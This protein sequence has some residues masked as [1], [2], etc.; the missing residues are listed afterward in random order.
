MFSLRLV[1]SALGM[2]HMYLDLL[3]SIDHLLQKQRFPSSPLHGFLLR[4]ERVPAS[5][6]VVSPRL[7]HL[8]NVIDIKYYL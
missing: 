2:L 4:N 8:S 1:R 7:A 3:H 5:L 6:Q